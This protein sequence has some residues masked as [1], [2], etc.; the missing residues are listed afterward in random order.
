[1]I[2]IEVIGQR[3]V[4][5]KHDSCSNG[6]S[7]NRTGEYGQGGD[8]WRAVVE[9]AIDSMHPTKRPSLTNQKPLV[10]K[11]DFYPW[12]LLNKTR[13]KRLVNTA[14]IQR[15][16]T[17]VKLIRSVSKKF[18]EWYQKTNKTKRSPPTVL[19]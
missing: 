19:P 18:G 1:M 10:S 13:Q 7:R 15:D 16:V 12:S 5:N 11:K 8:T 3:N 2:N 14:V 17:G 4:D 6:S 9:T